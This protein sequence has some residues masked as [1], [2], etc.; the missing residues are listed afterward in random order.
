MKTAIL[1]EL[2]EIKSLLI[3][4]MSDRWITL[5]ELCDYVSLSPSTIRRA[6]KRGELKVSRKTGKLLFRISDISNWLNG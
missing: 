3:K 5:N 4:K 2:R 6:I 1:E